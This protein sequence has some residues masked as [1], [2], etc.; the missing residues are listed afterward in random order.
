MKKVRVY[1]DTSVISHLQQEDVPEK[2]EQTK[3][4][5]EILQT[6]KYEIVIS[7]LVLAEINE[8]REPKRSMLK[9]YLSIINYEK[10]GITLETEEIANEIIAEGILGARSFDDCLHIASAILSDC[11]IILSWNFK[12]MVNI[13]TINGIRRITFAKRYN[14]I[15]IYAPYVLLNEKD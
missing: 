11:N 13:D 9:E 2:V 3:K 10:V 4:V 14:N 6:G 12:H 8:C 1:L 15:D 5:W 7:D